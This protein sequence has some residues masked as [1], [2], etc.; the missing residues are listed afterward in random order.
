MLT[1]L[2]PQQEA[3]MPVVRDEWINRAL[4]GT[5]RPKLSE[6]R[7]HVEWLYGLAKLDAPGIILV[8]DSPLAAQIAANLFGGAN[9]GANIGANIRDSVWD[10]ISGSILDSVWANISDNVGN[11]VWNSVGANVQANI[12]VNVQVNVQDSVLAS[13]LDTVGA[14]VQAG[15]WDNVGANVWDSVAAN[16]LDTVGDS[17]RVSVRDSIRNSVG[18]SV[19]ANVAA[20]VWANVGANVLDSVWVSVRDAKLRWYQMGGSGLGCDAGWTAFYDFFRRIG[21]ADLES[22]ENFARWTNFLDLRVWNT[23][24]LRGCAIICSTPSTVHRDAR[25]R[26][27]RLGGPAVEWHDG[28]RNYAIAGVRMDSEA[29]LVEDPSK[30][31]LERIL[32]ERNA[33][34]RKNL[35]LALDPDRNRAYERFVEMAGATTVH[36]DVD[37]RGGHRRLLAISAGQDQTW[38]L[39]EV[40]CPSKGDRHYLMVPPTF[41]A[42]GH[43]DELGTYKPRCHDAVAWTAHKSPED[44]RPLVEA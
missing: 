24:L 28:Y 33:E 19:A 36:Q 5:R 26:L 21:V 13:V 14:N 8:V 32:G 37:A 10:S 38:C 31:T 1:S 30:I 7:P 11:S 27:H 9:T 20:N 44:Y 17:V 16:V 23:I 3:L 40:T 42:D 18:N 2:T 35:V 22:H 25:G 34:L 6:V 4:D 12:A 29:E 43:T 41:A 15:V 39:L